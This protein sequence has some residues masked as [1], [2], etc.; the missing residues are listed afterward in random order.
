MARKKISKKMA[1][2]EMP[3]NV[4]EEDLM[5]VELYQELIRA[6]DEVN[7]VIKDLL[8][9]IPGRHPLSL[10]PLV[11][12]LALYRTIGSLVTNVIS[13]ALKG[14]RVSGKVRNEIYM[15]ARVWKIMYSKMMTL[16]V[17][18]EIHELIKKK[19]EGRNDNPLA[20][21]K[22]FL[23]KKKLEAIQKL[24]PDADPTTLPPWGFSTVTWDKDEVIGDDMVVFV[25]LVT[26]SMKVTHAL[27]QR[28]LDVDVASGLF[29][30]YRNE[31][32]PKPKDPR[33]KRKS[34][35]A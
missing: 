19:G 35:A 18:Q 15:A 32:A 3:K 26:Q 33:K 25:R 22:N 8:R 7:A 23:D 24:F 14:I 34:R 5:G 6:Y 28:D 30:H 10:S 2:P 17:P 9:S 20:A 13:P 29:Y 1:N 27:I 16:K 12:T 11:L 4:T 31:W 21:P